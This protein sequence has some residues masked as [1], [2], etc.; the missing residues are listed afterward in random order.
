M[1]QLDMAAKSAAENLLASKQ[2]SL[3]IAAGHRI[4]LFSCWGRPTCFHQ[5]LG[6]TVAGARTSQMEI[7]SIV[8]DVSSG[9][10]KAMRFA[11]LS[12][13]N[14]VMAFPTYHYEISYSNYL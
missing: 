6:H 13:I 10:G 1:R 12:T 9:G 3:S 4:M 5:Q 8:W 2:Y 7:G 11:C 14:Y